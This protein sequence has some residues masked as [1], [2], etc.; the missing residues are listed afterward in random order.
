M[1][2][3]NLIWVFF[4]FL[5]LCIKNKNNE[6]KFDLEDFIEKL[7]DTIKGKKIEIQK[8][9]ELWNEIPYQSKNI[10]YQHIPLIKKN[11]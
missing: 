9:E 7:I 4:I 6:T 5:I 2:K 8:F 10:F 11:V 1:K 3:M